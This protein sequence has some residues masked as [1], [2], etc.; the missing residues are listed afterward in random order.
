MYIIYVSYIYNYLL[1]YL[2]NIRIFH[3]IIKYFSSSACG[4]QLDPNSYLSFGDGEEDRGDRYCVWTVNNPS[5]SNSSLVVQFL[6]LSFDQYCSNKLRIDGGGWE[7]YG[8]FRV[9]FFKMS[10]IGDPCVCAEVISYWENRV[11]WKNYIK[12]HNYWHHILFPYSSVTSSGEE[13]RLKEICDT[14]SAPPVLVP[15]HTLRIT[16][17]QVWESSK[18]FPLHIL[19]L[20]SPSH[21]KHHSHIFRSFL[22]Q[23]KVPLQKLT[24]ILTH[25]FSPPPVWIFPWVM[26]PDSASQSLRRATTRTAERHHIAKLP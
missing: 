17:I 2:Y 6:S 8:R 4:G 16:Y 11:I 19:T 21:R 9:F 13:V 3:L 25:A 22:M 12:Y 20:P 15:Y 26:E 18:C 23:N 1:I 5:L 10:F 24:S 14:T 7:F